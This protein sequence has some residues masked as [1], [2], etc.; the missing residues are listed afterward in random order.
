[1]R[2]LNFELRISSGEHL[3]IT[4]TNG[5]GKTAIARVIAG[6]WVGSATAGISE[7]KAELIRPSLG[8][9]ELFVVPQRAYMVT[10]TLL[11]Q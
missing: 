1:M 5:V 8:S 3:M 7:S 2:D 9:M 11:D 6:L 4:G 10:G